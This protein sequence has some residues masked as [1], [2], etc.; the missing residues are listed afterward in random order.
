MSKKLEK[1]LDEIRDEAWSML[2]TVKAVRGEKYAEVVRMLLNIKQ[3]V[4]L[5]HIVTAGS[6]EMIEQDEGRQ[7]VVAAQDVMASLLTQI[8]GSAFRIGNVQESL[9]REAMKDSDAM[10]GTVDKLIDAAF[11]ADE[12]GRKF[13]G[14]DAK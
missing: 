2:D 10:M 11:M 7:A 8:A 1:S 9:W 6:L 5:T 3:A 4:H 13:G 12:T 14:T